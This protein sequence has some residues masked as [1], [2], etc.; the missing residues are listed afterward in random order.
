MARKKKLPSEKKRRVS[1]ELSGPR[2]IEDEGC[3]NVGGNFIIEDNVWKP[4]VNCDFG[5][6]NF[7]LEQDAYQQLQLQGTGCLKHLTQV[8]DPLL[9][10]SLT[11]ITSGAPCD[12]KNT[13]IE[14]SVRLMTFQTFDE[15]DSET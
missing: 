2:G 12:A 6:L 13:T 9:T 1:A 11:P 14:H 8:R 15:S 7:F 3:K 5:N 10:D 4:P